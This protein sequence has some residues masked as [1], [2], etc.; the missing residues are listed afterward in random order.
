MLSDS[1][2]RD[3]AVRGRRSRA[4]TMVELLVVIAVIGVL[5]GLLL[6]VLSMVKR[7]G[8]QTVEMTAGRQL[9]TGYSAYASNNEEAVM[10]GYWQ[11]ASAFNASGQA[12]ASPIVAGR[13]PW[14]IAPFLNYQFRGLY[15]NEN[16]DLLEKFEHDPFYEYLVSVFP[17]LGLNTTWLGGDETDG[18][19]NPAYRDTFGRFYVTRI[20]E[21]IHPDR[22]M[23]FASARG[24]DPTSQLGEATFEGY[25][26][27]RSPYFTSARWSEDFQ[28]DAP[29]V[30][31][32]YISPRYQDSAVVAFI[33]GHVDTLT[34]K[35]LRDMRYWANKAD[36]EDWTLTP[37]QQ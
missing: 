8:R 22:L 32:G 13:Y 4:F 24:G 21:V 33:D 9:M 1:S 7:S 34:A 28:P 17:S 6:P 3:A 37:L 11:Q 5:L 18:G 25:F 26:R 15:T 14:R 19:F 30:E 35:Q 2:P 23:A 31:Y 16:L 20:T 29:P 27:I 12:I 36:R 10:P